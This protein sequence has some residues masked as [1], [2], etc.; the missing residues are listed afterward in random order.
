MWAVTSFFSVI[1]NFRSGYDQESGDIGWTVSEGD[2]DRF[3]RHS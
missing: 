3:R 1:T 2:E